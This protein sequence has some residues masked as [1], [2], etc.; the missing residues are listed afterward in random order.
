MT[1]TAGILHED[2]YTSMIISRPVL[3]RMRNISE[4][5]CREN[6]NT[7]FVFRNIF[8]KSCCLLGNVKKYGKTRQ[9]TDDNT[10]RRTRLAC[11]VTKATDT[12]SECYT[13]CFCTA[14]MIARTRL[15]VTLYVSRLSCVSC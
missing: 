3:L 4:K 2:R 6:Q 11:R 1:R 10:I 15:R 8:R 5:I 9:A 13:Y 14:I 12:C 7:H